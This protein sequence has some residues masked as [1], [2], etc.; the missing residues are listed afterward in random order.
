MFQFSLFNQDYCN[1][2]EQSYTY[3]TLFSTKPL[4]NLYDDMFDDSDIAETLAEAYFELNGFKNES[5]Q[6]QIEVKS[7]SSDYEYY[8]NGN[9]HYYKKLN[10]KFYEFRE[11]NEIITRHT[12]FKNVKYRLY[13]PNYDYQAELLQLISE[14]PTIN[15]HFFYANNMD[16]ERY[17]KALNDCFDSDLYEFS[18]EKINLDTNEVGLKLIYYDDTF[19]D[20]NDLIWKMRYNDDGI[21]YYASLIYENEY[22][23]KFELDGFNIIWYEN[24]ILITLIITALITIA[25]LYLYVKYKLK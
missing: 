14:Y 1:V 25:I 13:E 11:K 19:D 17:C 4:E 9:A 3:N 23:F 8:T 5:I 15:L 12:L 2:K 21:L 18:I 22:I 20:T 24:W 16:Y 7:I 10:C 6:W